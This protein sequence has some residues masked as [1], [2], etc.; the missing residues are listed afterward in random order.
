MFFRICAIIGSI[1]AL[2]AV[3]VAQSFPPG[4]LDPEP[5]I[6]AA[7]T[8][9]G[10]QDLDCVTLSGTAYTGMVGQQRLNGYDVDWPRGER[11]TEYSRIMNWRDASMVETFTRVPGHNP[12]SWKHG[13]GWRGGTPIQVNSRQTF[14]VNGLYAWHKDGEESSPIAAHPDDAERWQLDLWL[15]PHGFLKAAR[16]PGA[17]PRATWRWELGEM[18]RDGATVTP[19]KVRI[20]SITVLDKYRVDAT[21]NS[22]N[23]L[24]R[25]HTW[26][27]DP[28][29]GDMNY[30]HEFTNES[31]VDI[32]DGIQFPTGW[33][34]HEGWDDNYQA[35][36]VNA[37]HNAFGGNLDQIQANVCSNPIS[38]PSSVASATFDVTVDVSELAP[39]VWL[40][41]GTSHNSVAIE[42]DT[43]TAI[44]E[45]PLNEERSLA[46]IDAVTK[47]VPEKPIRF[48]VNTH[49][50]HDHIGGLRTYMHIGA[51]IITHWKNYDF[52]VQDV[53]NYA[54]RSL[55]PDMVALWPPTELAEG[56]QYETVRENYWLRDNSRSMHVSYVHPL[57]HVEGMLIA[58]L[59]ETGLLIE[60]D[61]FDSF[62]AE[63]TQATDANRSLYRHVQRLGLDVK[64]IVPI[65]GQPVPW[66]EFLE[67]IESTN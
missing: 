54:P 28:V 27:P 1:P 3:L 65:H 38:V 26:V 52:Y 13:L 57:A 12:A 40:L 23:L 60:A 61:L 21:I 63:P 36:S 45:A 64:T 41:G 39:G 7:E 44:V 59:P 29:L 56:Y 6:R 22:E 50:H 33:H 51:T 62:S 19:E 15:N 49:Q 42:F 10:T 16:L 37:G 48:L 17:N 8:A 53:L 25:I 32:G 24:Q 4:Y 14:A 20:V 5:I 30:E 34:H 11:L 67:L 66:S 18:G 46:V 9:I 58:Y 2:G 47:L 43:Y 31:Y 55:N 35:Q